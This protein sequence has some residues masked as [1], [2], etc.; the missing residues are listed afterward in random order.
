MKPAPENK[1]QPSNKSSGMRK[2]A[3]WKVF[4]LA[5]ITLGIYSIVWYA[6]RRGEMVK[7]YQLAVP[8]IWWPL[9]FSLAFVILITVA[10]IYLSVETRADSDLFG[11]ITVLGSLITFGALVPIT[12]WWALRFSNGA[13]AVTNGQLS[14][15]WSVLLFLFGPTWAPVVIQP[16]FNKA[17]KIAKA[18]AG[19]QKSDRKFIVSALAL[20]LL[21][22]IVTVAVIVASKPIYDEQ[23][24][25][26]SQNSPKARA[27]QEVRDYFIEVAI[28]NDPQINPDFAIQ[29][30][31]KP[32]VTVMTEGYV[33]DLSS[34]C[35]QKAVTTFNKNSKETQLKIVST[36][37]ADISI[38]FAARE[39]FKSILPDYEPPSWGWATW[40]YDS[41]WAN[42]SATILVDNSASIADDYRCFIINSMLVSS[43]GLPNTS[44][45][46]T[47]SVFYEAETETITFSKLDQ[48]L[49]EILY[50]GYGI[51]AGDIETEV[52]E[53][54]EI[55]E[56]SPT[57]GQ[58]I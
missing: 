56:E 27:T 2:I 52:I 1:K 26:A 19:K 16:Y 9:S 15:L 7:K 57:P 24:Q 46:H 39:D 13:A 10:V 34:K 30:W 50:G 33:P 44:T 12:I 17:K 45:K 35:L 23:Q 11:I 4:L 53:R 37:G 8:S 3:I 38:H 47:D 5:T 21:E 41:S 22:L 25:Q 40:D 48:K 51:E 6:R 54:F 58:A 29:K 55:V 31:D 42:T 32:E 43:M 14:V 18:G 36:G 49:I 20:I 28:G